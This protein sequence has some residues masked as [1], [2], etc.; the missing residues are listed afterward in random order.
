MGI[1]TMAAKVALAAEPEYLQV[2]SVNIWQILIS[3]AN[4][5]LLFLILKK[6][7]YK[8]VKKVLDARKAAIDE[9]N[10]VGCKGERGCSCRKGGVG[11]K[12]RPRRK[13]SR[14]HF[15]AGK[16]ERR[17]EERQHCRGRAEGSRRD[18]SP[19]REG[20][21]AGA[22]KGG[23]RHPAGAGRPFPPSLRKSCWSVRSMKMITRS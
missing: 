14:R 2:V 8:P 10:R 13:R 17:A 22:Q 11:G 15:A 12:A 19:R 7:L 1:E 9:E 16:D 23:S 3:L 18:P 5:L 4:L 6:F 21:R 20:R